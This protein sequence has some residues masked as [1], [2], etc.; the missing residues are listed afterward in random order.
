MVLPKFQ[1]NANANFDYSNKTI[2]SLLRIEK[3]RFNVCEPKEVKT[4]R[5]KG[6]IGEVTWIVHVKKNGKMT[7][8]RL[9]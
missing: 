5:Y 7:A 1:A 2:E 3:D 8:K 6:L 9:N 4:R